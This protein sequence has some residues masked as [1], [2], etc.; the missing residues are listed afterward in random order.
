MPPPSLKIVIAGAGAIGGY[1]VSQFS[2]QGHQVSIIDVNSDRFDRFPSVPRERMY[3]GN[4]VSSSV[5]ARAGAGSADIFIASSNQHEANA[6]SAMKARRMGAARVVALIEKADY[7]DDPVGIYRDW[8][9]IDLVLNTRFLVAGEIAKVIRT[10]GVLAVDAFVEHGFEMVQFRVQAETEHTGRPLRD[11][12]LPEQTLVV[13][14]N[15]DGVLTIPRGDDSVRA[16]DEV[17]VLSS[18]DKIPFVERIFGRSKVAGHKT[19]ILGGGTV[20]HALARQIS[21]R[22]SNITVIERD[23]DRCDFLSRELDRTT[24]IYGDGSDGD[25]LNEEGVGSAE[26]FAAVTGDDEKNIIAATLA[27][28]LGAERC[29]AKVSR[30]GYESVCRH[31]GLEM[32]RSPDRIVCREIVRALLPYGVLSETPVMGGQAGFVEMAPSPGC[33]VE[34]RILQEAGF[35]PG[36]VLCGLFEGGRFSIPHG[37]TTIR[38]GS[39]AIIFCSR[40]ARPVIDRLFG[41]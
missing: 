19:V 32:V 38:S 34:G 33:P 27:R 1:L 31:I 24:V 36:A 35:P 5:L 37:Q 40:E 41:I 20:G 28:A 17:L 23:L 6:L 3:V 39:R 18:V 4:L 25:L 21:G 14:L 15:R 7:F 22:A 10:R 13:A 12:R 8:F 2:G 16:G 26:V 11:L 9:G 29:I 30:S